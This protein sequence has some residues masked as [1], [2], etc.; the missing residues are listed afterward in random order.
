[1]EIRKPKIGLFAGGIECYWVDM[2]MDELPARLQQDVDRLIASLDGEVVFP[3]LA[4]NPAQSAEAGRAI[5][6]A[7]CDIAVVYH[8]TFIADDMTVAFL[9]ALMSASTSDPAAVLSL[10]ST[11]PGRSAPMPLRPL[12]P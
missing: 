6:E 5:R 8:A 10:P 9:D 1:M 4:G 11:P 12:R 3:C 2:S 7:Q